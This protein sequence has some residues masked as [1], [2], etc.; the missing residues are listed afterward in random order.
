MNVSKWSRRVR[1]CVILLGFLATALVFGPALAADAQDWEND[2]DFILHSTYQAVNPD[3]T[4]SYAGDFPIK[5][6]GV[7]LNNTED[8]LDPRENYNTTTGNL[9]GQAEFY[10]QA[11]DMPGDSWDDDDFGGTA[12]W[13]GQNYGNLP[14]IGEPSIYSY[15]NSDYQGDEPA[16]WYDQ[17]DGLHLYRPATPFGDADLVRAGDLVEVRARG[18]LNYNGKMNVNEKHH[19]DPAYDFEVE[20]LQKGYGLPDPIGIALREIVDAESVPIFDPSRASGGE[21]YQSTLVEIQ[22]VRFVNDSGWASDSDLT[23]IDETG[24]TLDVHLG[25]N[26]SFDSELPPEG[27]PPEG[28]FNLVGIMDQKSSSG[29]DGYRLL[30]MR[31]GDFSPIPEPAT[32][33]LLAAGAALLLIRVW[34]RRRHNT[35]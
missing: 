35:S 12:C 9:G 11:V 22:N 21:R 29:I 2:V 15:Q 26:E 34:R 24:R 31:A 33:M 17:L 25:L 5:L 4:G 7:V 19:N 32:V 14:W 30:A 13:M 1:P 10:L 16:K 8:W 18:G 6:R 3:G 23:L 28:Y 27:Y 20:I